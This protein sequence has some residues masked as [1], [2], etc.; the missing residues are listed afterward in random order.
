M[1]KFITI[2]LSLIIVALSL[3]GCTKTYS[4]YLYGLFGA[5]GF[6]TF[7]CEDSS[8]FDDCY[9]E[10]Y[11]IF[12][13]YNTLTATYGDNMQALNNLPVNQSLAVTQDFFNLVKTA[14]EYYDFTNGYFNPAVYGLNVLWNFSTDTYNGASATY[15]LP[16]TE[17][18]NEVMPFTNFNEVV[19][20]ANDLSITKTNN[21]TVD[22]GG[23]AKGYALNLAKNVV[24]NY[25]F[26]NGYIS[27]G[28]SSILLFGEHEVAIKHPINSNVSD[29]YLKFNVSGETAIATSGDYQRYY[30]IDGKK[31]C[32]IIN[33][34]TGKPI[35][36]GAISVTVVGEDAGICDALS[37]A[38]MAMDKNDAI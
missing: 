10:I 6:I 15:T 22:L 23:F 14:K 5:D 9:N 16:T 21:V 2:L 13:N 3:S 1:K 18:I 31:Y 11:S 30:Y 25:R 28:S 7:E 17:Q 33:P 32:H 12:N 27:L 29:T 34:F 8:D 24:K 26:D 19:L 38:L 20:N 37:T 4:E 35:E 36:T